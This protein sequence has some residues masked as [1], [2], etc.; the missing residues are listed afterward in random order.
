MDIFAVYTRLL[1]IIYVVVDN[2]WAHIYI[3]AFL[4]YV[5]LLSSKKTMWGD[6]TTIWNDK[7]ARVTLVEEV[8]ETLHHLIDTF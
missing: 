7:T 8:D 3:K 2:E 5:Q 6:K 4:I 1:D